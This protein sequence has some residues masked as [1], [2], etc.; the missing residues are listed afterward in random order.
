MDSKAHVSGSSGVKPESGNS[1]SAASI[2]P[3]M[4]SS[5]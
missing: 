1:P 2:C 5:A 4:H 3:S